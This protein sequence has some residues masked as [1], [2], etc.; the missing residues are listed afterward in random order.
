MTNR[1]YFLK[2]RQMEAPILES[3]F[4]A[5]PDS[6]LDWKPEPKARSARELLGHLIGHEQDLVE[7]AERGEINHRMH[8]E[9]KTVDEAV[10]LFK[11]ACGDAD[12]KLQAIGDE[13]W[14]GKLG[15]FMVNGAT[16]F[17]A[18]QRDLGWMMLFDSVHHRGQLSTYLRPMGSR[19]PAMYGPSADSV[20]AV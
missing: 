8:V 20:A 9:F 4:R 6:Q 13:T 3:V 14:D 18:P 5:V 15:R 19:V 2:R 1:E 16:V 17:E 10:N 11:K 7:L 12:A